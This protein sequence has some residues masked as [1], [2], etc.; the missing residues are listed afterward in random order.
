MPELPLKLKFPINASG[1]I[2]HTLLCL[3]HLLGKIKRDAATHIVAI[4]NV[5]KKAARGIYKRDNGNAR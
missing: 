3:H 4:G 1:N 5:A 2:F